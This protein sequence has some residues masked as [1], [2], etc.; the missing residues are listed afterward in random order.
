MNVAARQDAELLVNAVL[1]FAEQMLKRYGEFYPYG[2]YTTLTG[3]IIE[4]GAE[5]N[6][7]DYPRSKEPLITLRESLRSIA[8]AK[9]CRA[10]AIVSN[11]AITIPGS[12]QKTDAI[13]VIIDIVMV[14]QLTSSIHIDWL[15]VRCATARSSLR[16][17]ITTFSC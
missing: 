13:Q 7:I 17:G 4:G 8:K 14:I 5:R 3:E 1:P 10:A 2:G 6:R 12:D 15:M 16:Q 11:V 9:K